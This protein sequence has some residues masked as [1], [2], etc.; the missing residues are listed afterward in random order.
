MFSAVANWQINPRSGFI[1][2]LFPEEAT[3]AGTRRGVPWQPRKGFGDRGPGLENEVE[4]TGGP[5]LRNS[6]FLKG[7]GSDLPLVSYF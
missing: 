5:H 6:Q 1:C 4:Y 2:G 3:A 7:K